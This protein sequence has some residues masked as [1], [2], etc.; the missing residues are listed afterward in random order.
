MG[1]VDFGQILSFVVNG[2]FA[3][4]H[5]PIYHTR[6]YRQVGLRVK[7]GDK[8]VLTVVLFG[9]VDHLI[10]HFQSLLGVVTENEGGQVRPRLVVQLLVVGFLAERTFSVYASV[11]FVSKSALASF[12]HFSLASSSSFDVSAATKEGIQ[13]SHIRQEM[14]ILTIV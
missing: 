4:F 1:A 3:Q 14:R 7:S 9:I 11:S 2:L 8:A 5:R 13:T 6:F 10:G 12:L